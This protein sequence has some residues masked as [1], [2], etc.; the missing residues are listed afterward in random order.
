M[1]KHYDGTLTEDVVLMPT[2]AGNYQLGPVSYTYFDP[3]SGTYT[4]LTTPAV[5][6][7]ITAAPT[8]S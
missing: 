1:G 5:S 4:T 6:L 8:A 3:E 2:K 7:A